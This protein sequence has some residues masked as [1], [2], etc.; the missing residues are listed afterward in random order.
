MVALWRVDAAHAVPVSRHD[1]GA[2]GVVFHGLGIVVG[3]GQ[4]HAFRVDNRDARAG[5]LRGLARP[6]FQLG[7]RNIG[8]FR[9]Q[10]SRFRFQPLVLRSALPDRRCSG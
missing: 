6:I 2:G 5:T 8:G 7:A 1:F 10:N 9:L 4:G 3:I